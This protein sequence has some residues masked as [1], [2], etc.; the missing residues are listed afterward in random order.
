MASIHRASWLAVPLSLLVSCSSPPPT[1]APAKAEAPKPVEPLSRVGKQTWG[2]GNLG[3][4]IDLYTLRNAQGTE[5]SITNYGATIVS[6]KTKDRAGKAGEIT[7]GFDGIEGYLGTHPYFG[8]VVGRYANRIAKGKFELGGLTYTLA[9]NDGENHLHGG[10]KGFDKG[11][12]EAR[13]GAD[14][15]ELVY[16]SR[17]GEEGYPGNLTVKVTY[18]LSEENALK[19]DY[20]ATTDRDTYLNLSNHAYFNLAG[21]GDILAHEVRI[22]A[23]KFTP[24]DSGLIP[25]G[26][27][28]PVKGT[29]FDFTKATTVGARIEQND[30]Q[31]RLGKGYD[32]NF[33]LN[34]GGTAVKE[35]AEVYEP[36]SGRVLTV[37]T[38]QPGLQ[39]YTGNFL[40]GTIKG[41]GGKMIPR[42]GALCLETQHFPDSPNKPAFPTTLLKTGQAF[43]STTTFQFSA[44]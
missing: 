8:A 10:K 27:L 37:S 29:P 16:I 3:N 15:L 33:V 32:H 11:M 23:D 41:R 14:S 40:D 25:T 9:T 1:K 13:P 19:I 38:D 18:S 21:G 5:V 22:D 35:V 7:L 43:H 31:L 24:V 6:I 26:E 34:T 4:A 39:F 17:D 44:R 28:K 20:S 42:R 2:K 36:G 30:P 12:W